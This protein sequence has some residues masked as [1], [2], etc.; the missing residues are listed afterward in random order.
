MRYRPKAPYA[1]SLSNMAPKPVTQP[2]PKS[3][4][5]C[6]KE[7]YSEKKNKE[8]RQLNLQI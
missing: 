3:T 7:N 5:F 2:T 4:H 1:Y 8:K 6:M